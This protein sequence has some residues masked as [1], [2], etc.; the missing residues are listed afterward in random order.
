M[1]EYMWHYLIVNAVA[2][3]AL[4]VG[5]WIKKRR[6]DTASVILSAWVIGALGSVWYYT[7]FT[8]YIGYNKL[9]IWPLIYLFG[10]NL[11]MFWPWMRTDYT[12]LNS[13]DTDSISKMLKLISIG[14]CVIGILPL[15]NLLY[16][17][18]SF[19][20]ASAALAEMYELEDD[21]ASV[22]FAPMIKPMYSI[23]RHFTQLII[24]LFFYN[25]SLP[26]I[27]RPIV[28]GLGLCI[29]TFLLFALLSGSRGGIMLLLV[30]CVFYVM[31]LKNIYK[32]KIYRSMMKLA[33]V[34]VGLLVVGIA[35]ISLSRVDSMNTS[36][37]NA[38]EIMM[39]QWIAQ[40]AGEG[41]IQFDNDLW[42]QDKHLWGMQNLS[43]PMSLYEKRL[44][45]PDKFAFHAERKIH[46]PI[47]VF[48]TYVGDLYIDFG[49]W[50]TLLAVLLLQWFSRKLLKFKNGKI[51]IYK[52]IGLNYMFVYLSIGFTA[53]IY[54]TFYTQIEFV[55]V[56]VFLLL[57]FIYQTISRV[58][59]QQRVC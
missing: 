44:L 20:M 16:D 31:M 25:L 2:Y 22:L 52:L 35:A 4:F 26:R 14:F 36:N 29:V 53:N 3:V 27:N 39:D 12:Q 6:Y 40:Y 7:F 17:M 11:I 28:V 33:S 10:V 57:L 8:S 49:A 59:A 30:S 32:P 15:L 43:V 50:G 54:R 37:K 58:G 48:Y 9:T 42:P 19:S 41:M 13:V 1:K 21:T 38:P 55:Y 23:M 18:K 56:G 46:N 45:D 47:T 24:F 34:A 5:Y 51:S